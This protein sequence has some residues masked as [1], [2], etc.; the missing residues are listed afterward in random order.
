MAKK[1][2]RLIFNQLRKY[3]KARGLRQSDAARILGL[4]DASSISRW[5]RGVCLPSV[6][7]LFRLAALYGTLVDALFIDVLRTIRDEIR[8]LEADLLQ[9]DHHDH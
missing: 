6:V 3:R 9:P 5:E 1:K 7:N 2:T 8:G 4:A